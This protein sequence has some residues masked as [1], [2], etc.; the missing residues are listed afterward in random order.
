M[1]R[2][3][4]LNPVP[5]G[6]RSSRRCLA[7]PRANPK[8]L[9]DLE[10][11]MQPHRRERQ[12]RRGDEQSRS[13]GLFTPAD[14]TGAQNRAEF[15]R[16]ASQYS[17]PFRRLDAHHIS[18]RHWAGTSPWRPSAKTGG[19]SDHADRHRIAQEFVEAVDALWRSPR[20]AHRDDAASGQ[21]LTLARCGQRA[22]PAIISSSAAH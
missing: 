4:H 9:T 10:L 13:S 2:Q 14:R 7:P 6:A 3:L 21:F 8:A 17:H 11:R 19:W 18:K 1:S 22:I 15:M 5:D 12:V 20:P 16:T